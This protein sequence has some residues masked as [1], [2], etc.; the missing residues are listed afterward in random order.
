MTPADIA[1]LK[2]LL[3]QHP[4]LTLHG[5]GEFNQ[6]DIAT[7]QGRARLME[8]TA[9]IDKVQRLPDSPNAWLN[10]SQLGLRRSGQPSDGWTPA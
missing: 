3:K 8:A 9:E 5:F 2:T 6:P 7:D 4:L 10:I 1:R